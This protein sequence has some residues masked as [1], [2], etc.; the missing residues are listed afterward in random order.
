MNA[1]SES[2][3][4][5]SVDVMFALFFDAPEEVLMPRLINRGKTSGRA[6]D[7]AESIMKRFKTFKNESIPVVQMFKQMGRLQSINANKQPDEVL[8]FSSSSNKKKT[9]TK[10]TNDANKTIQDKTN[11]PHQHN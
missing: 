6:D 5:E 10:Q 2:G 4:D 9:N 11:K 8:F 1:W 3:M 7:N